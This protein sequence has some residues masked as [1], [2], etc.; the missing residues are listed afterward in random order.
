M[1]EYHPNISQEHVL[2]YTLCLNSVVACKTFLLPQVQLHCSAGVV[3]CLLLKA[4]PNHGFS[5]FWYGC[6]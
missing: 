4:L 5:L 3:S 6:F 2:N 1:W